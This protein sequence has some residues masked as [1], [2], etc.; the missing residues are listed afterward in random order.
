MNALRRAIG[1]AAL[2]WPAAML[3]SPPVQAAPPSSPS[4]PAQAAT[5]SYVA[6]K[7]DNLYV[8]AER[9]LTRQ[10]DFAVV[11]RLNRIADPYRI[12]IGRTIRIPVA[13]L[14]EELVSASVRAFSGP[15]TIAVAGRPVKITPGLPVNEGA[16]IETGADAFLSLRLADGST[17]AIP[18]Q[19]RVRIERL[20]RT[21]LTGTVTR[22]FEIRR[23]RA[24]A[25]VAPMKDPGSSFHISTPVAV[26]AVRGTAFRVAY[27]ADGA[28]AA[29]EV[30]E[31]TVGFSAPGNPAATLVGA[32]FGA[33]TETDGISAPI[34]LLPAPALADP[35]RVQNES[36][37]TFRI[38]PQADA[39]AYRIALARDA[40]FLD[41]VREKESATPD[42][43]LPPVADGTYFVRIA[44]IDGHGLAGLAETYA[45]ERRLNMVRTAMTE[46]RA[47][48]DRYYQFGWQ[49]LGEGAHRF[50]F[51]LGQC[52][53]DAP[54]LVDEIGLDSQSVTLRNLPAGTYCWRVMSLRIG[55]GKA[56]G[57]WS[58]MERFHI[59]SAR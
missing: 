9:Y 32:G 49:V 53:G 17:V 7:G 31:G 16:E 26:S 33:I 23:G 55:D 51:Q 35:G 41:I 29:T 25:V 54:P 8:I 48:R 3:W 38:V 34:A 57:D 44:A 6:V 14:R 59:A 11:Q 36:D 42:A 18:S 4:A 19:S 5:A 12:P 21:A 52:E 46:K 30:T 10:R 37:L 58:A 40:G 43:I 27:D 28:R 22:R 39:A 1:P 2:L 56:A 45:F 24:D 13:L 50:R 15:V 47:G 20:R